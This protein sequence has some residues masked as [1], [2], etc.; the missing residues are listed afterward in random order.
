M[1]SK[2]LEFLKKDRF[3]K[4]LDIISIIVGVFIIIYI[5]YGFL[6]FLKDTR[7]LPGTLMFQIVW[8]GLVITLILNSLHRLKKRNAI[9]PVENISLE[10]PYRKY[11]ISIS[12][13]IFIICF[14]RFAI[15]FSSNAWDVGI[16]LGIWLFG[17]QLPLTLVAIFTKNKSTLQTICVLSVLFGLGLFLI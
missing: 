1:N 12:I 5:L 9:Q 14:V 17:F 13:I 3:S 15:F 10:I 8:I 4:T 6:N 7:E 11:L 16:F 2:L